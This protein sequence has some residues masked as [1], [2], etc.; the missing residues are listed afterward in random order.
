MRS[1]AAGTKALTEAIIQ[2]ANDSELL[3][4]YSAANGSFR[5][6]SLREVIR[7][8]GGLGR[9]RILAV[10]NFPEAALIV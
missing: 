6:R 2:E 5:T 4:P 10:A 3:S 7:E 9:G 1:E 8:F